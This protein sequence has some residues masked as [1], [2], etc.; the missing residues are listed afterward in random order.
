MLMSKNQDAST[1][2]SGK[3]NAGFLQRKNIEISLQRYGIDA[4]SAM[5]KGLFASL[6][7]G[8]I[9]DVIGDAA[10]IELLVEFGGTAQD[11]MGPAIGVAVASGLQAPGLVVFTSVI[12]GGA[13]AALGGP[14]GAL[15]AAIAGT[16]FGK[17]VSGETPVDIVITPMTT[18][19]VGLTVAEFVGPGVDAFMTALG[20]SIN[21]ATYLHPL[22]MGIIVSTLMGMAL[23]LP[24]SSAAIGIMLGL[25]GLAAGAAT[26]GCSAQMIGF[27]VTSF[28][29][30]GLEGLVSQGLGTSML[31]I[32]NIVRNPLI[33]L[34]PTLTGALLGP[35]ATVLLAMENSPVG[36]G[37]GTSG[38]V[39]QFGT[40]DVMGFS[41]S[42]LVQIALLHFLLP[43]VITLL[44]SSFMRKK[45][46]IKEGDM[47]LDL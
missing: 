29:E 9:L 45:N 17:A 38:F 1:D 26:A 8:L 46:L 21:Y 35:V 5:A 11:M 2:E 39:G 37:M 32:G 22:P 16:E 28:R 13:G 42:V 25:E 34:P 20:A 12:T 7:V 24:I 3:E 18:I 44:I 23:T 40:V 43:A 33:W 36:S 4:L 41:F 27:A 15:L 30:N 10:G 31:Q 6:I 47:N 14:V 19:I